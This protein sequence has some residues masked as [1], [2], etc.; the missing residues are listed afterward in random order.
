MNNT[1]IPENKINLKNYKASAMIYSLIFLYICS[2]I[3]IGLISL[4]ESQLKLASSKIRLEQ[5][6]KLADTGINIALSY[7]NTNPN[8]I[9]TIQDLKEFNKEQNNTFDFKNLN[10]YTLSVYIFDKNTVKK[11]YKY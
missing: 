1:Q 7:L 2:L 9:P 8:G 4:F 5:R 3:A 6:L 10:N 11:K